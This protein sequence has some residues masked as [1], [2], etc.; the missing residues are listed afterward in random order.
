MSPISRCALLIV[1]LLSP[2]VAHARGSSTTLWEVE[3]HR[4]L[5]E[6][7]IRKIVTEQVAAWNQGSAEAFTVAFASRALSTDC[8]GATYDD[9][10]SFKASRERLLKTI[11]KDSHLSLV[12]RQL[13]LANR[14]VAVVDI[15]AELSGFKGLPSGVNAWPDGVLRTRLQEVFVLTT[16]GWSVIGYHAVDAKVPPLRS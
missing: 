6:E 3:R 8:D 10:S 4:K 1:A 15:D 13:R 11:F 2:L 14:E 16:S 7:A 5:D 12:I 9:A